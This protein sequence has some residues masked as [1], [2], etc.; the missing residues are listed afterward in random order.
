MPAS[1]S[2]SSL[3][4]AIPCPPSHALPAARQP[5][6]ADAKRGIGGHGFFEAIADGTPR[7]DALARVADPETRAVCAKIDV[8]QVPRGG[9]TELAIAYDV[10]SGRARR[11]PVTGRKYGALPPTEIPGTMDLAI[12]D[13]LEAVVVDWK[14]ARWAFDLETYVPQLD[15]YSLAWA[16][17]CGAEGARWRVGV[18]TDDG[19]IGWHERRLDWEALAGVAARTR[20]THERVMLARAERAAHERVNV[21]QWQPDVTEGMHCAYCDA[22][23]ACP[24]KRAAVGAVMGLDPVTLSPEDAGRA[25]ARAKDAEAVIERLKG[26]VRAGVETLGPLP[27][28]DGR[29]VRLDGKGALRFA[30][31]REVA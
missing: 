11:L 2:G 29:I 8:R 19:A 12:P 24:S 9:V 27:T 1:L 6:T 10:A 13:S 28:G 25:W 30:R 16:R 18:V 14:F 5:S 20:R 23:A 21:A 7:E 22:I 17:I 4:R 15:F 31:E 3:V 26:A